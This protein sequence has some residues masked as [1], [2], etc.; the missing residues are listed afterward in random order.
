M[1]RAVLLAAGG[2]VLLVLLEVLIAS[3]RGYLPT[4]PAMAIGGAFGPPGGPPLKFAVLGDSTAAGV[5]AG[6]PE[7]SYPHLLAQRLGDA[8]YRVELFDFGVSGARTADVRRRQVPRAVAAQPDLVLVAAGANDVTH[9]T[10]REAVR[11]D[12]EATL[13]ALKATG[14]AV[15]VTG[16]PDM[17]VTAFL[18]PL[19]SIAGWR[20][21]AI[22]RTI[23]SVAAEKDVVFI[24]LAE[25][26]AEAVVKSSE[27]F[28]SDD[29]FH[30]SPA[31]YR[32]WAGAIFPGLEEA[33]ARR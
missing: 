23:R 28:F 22:A 32:G 7:K 20:G 4:R 11:R 8:G 16:A 2:A 18:E 14:A 12:M 31:G 6:S 1:G 5:G 15:A 19:R 33:L 13:D 29:E 26:T 17:R 3:L 30:P 9:L 27:S 21:R 24:P 25:R 10:P